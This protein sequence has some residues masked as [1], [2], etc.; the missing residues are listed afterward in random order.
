MPKLA[1]AWQFPT[2]DAVTATPTVVDGTVYAGSWDGWFYAVDLETGKLRWKYQLQAQDAV[3]PYPGQTPRDGTS[4]GG[5]VTS[6]AWFE[7]RAAHATGRTGPARPDLV[8]FAGG[9]TLYAL[10]AHTGALYWKHDY[11]GR[12]D[13]PPDPNHDGTRIFSSPVVVGGSVLF[14]VDTDGERA[15]RG[16][17]VGASLATGDPLWEYQTD[18][19][20]A[21]PHPRQRVREHLVLGD[22]AARR[23]P[24]G[25]R[26]RR[27]QLR[28]PPA[29]GRVGD[30][31]PHRHRPA[32]LDLPA[33]PRSERVRS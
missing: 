1:I 14:G 3:T 33:H 4:D 5:L 6:S 27:L 20:T 15:S 18:V 28:R 22:G 24:G 30:G 11:T 10:D 23:R 9:Y 12:P 25:V 17:A 32:G 7:P 21:G 19:D 8:I 13:Q 31:P 2:G 29:D 26:Q 16:Y